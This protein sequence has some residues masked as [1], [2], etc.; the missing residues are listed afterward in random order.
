[1]VVV[2]RGYGSDTLVARRVKLKNPDIPWR[3]PAPHQSASHAF[4]G[5]AVKCSPISETR[6][7]GRNLLASCAGAHRK[8]NSPRHWPKGAKGPAAREEYLLRGGGHRTEGA[9]RAAE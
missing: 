2:C 5:V 7:T 3:V 8:W 6:A 4:L 9:L 1:M